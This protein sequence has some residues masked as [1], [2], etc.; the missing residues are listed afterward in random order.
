MTL[1]PIYENYKKNDGSFAK[2]NNNFIVDADSSY[3][4]ASILKLV[5]T[6][7]GQSKVTLDWNDQN[8]TVTQK[9]YKI[10][11]Y[12]S[13]TT[14]WVDVIP[15]LS[16]GTPI[17]NGNTKTWNF[18]GFDYAVVKNNMSVSKRFIFKDA[19]LDSA[20]TLYD[21][22]EDSQY[23]YLATVMEY[24]FTG[25]DTALFLQEIESPSTKLKSFL[26][27]TFSITKQNLHFV[28]EH[29]MEPIEIKQRKRVINNK[30]YLIELVKM[31]KVKDAITAFPNISIW[32]NAEIIIDDQ[33][34]DDVAQMYAFNPDAN[35]GASGLAFIGDGFNLQQRFY[36]TI[37]RFNAL[38]DTMANHTGVTW[39]SGFMTLYLGGWAGFAAATDTIAMDAY[40]CDNNA[41][42]EGTGSGS[43][44]GGVTW[45]SV[46]D[47][48]GG[49]TGEVWTTGGGDFAA[50]REGVNHDSIF[51]VSGIAFD[52]P[53]VFFISGATISDTMNNGSGLVVRAY[54]NVG[55]A[56]QTVRFVSDDGS[57]SFQ[58]ELK[59]YYTS[60]A[61][62]ATPSRRRKTILRG[63]YSEKATFYSAVPAVVQ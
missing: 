8:I 22:R 34:D 38:N 46:D 37:I 18:P 15:S 11:W 55:P 47:A 25:I 31:S 57:S 41:W 35:Y 60:A 29:L 12:N 7:N 59:I 21:Q 50:T 5:V 32:H 43:D 26:R 58:P 61:A 9:P 49:G 33:V 42:V 45:N 53:F 30:I 4:D 2:I 1:S 62:E 51:A 14:N 44:V 56:T 16:W 63:E 19:F 3:V 39:D 40:L 17:V 23:I 10:V 48:S 27:H 28:G 54:V 24:S 36:H 6:D 13:Q 20:M 52:D